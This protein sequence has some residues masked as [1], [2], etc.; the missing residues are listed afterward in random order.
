MLEIEKKLISDAYGTVIFVF[1]Q[2]IVSS[3]NVSGVNPITLSPGYFWNF[4]EWTPVT[5]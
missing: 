4:W 1:P 3:S 5:E 2:L